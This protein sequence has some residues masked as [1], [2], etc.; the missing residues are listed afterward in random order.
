[1]GIENELSEQDI[2][3]ADVALFAT[4]IS[5]EG[6]DRFAH[7]RKMHVPVQSVLKDPLAVF[8]KL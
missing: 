7:I 4:D 6:E 3:S 8:A 1:M 5:V 2:K